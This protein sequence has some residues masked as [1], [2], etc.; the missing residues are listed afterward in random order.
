MLRIAPAN[1]RTSEHMMA[2]LELLHFLHRRQLHV[3]QPIA[4]KDGAY[5]QTLSAPEGPRYAVLFTFVPGAPYQPTTTDSQRY[6]QALAQ[7]H[8][9][10]HDYPADRAAWHF[11]PAAMI[12]QPLALLQPWFTDHP[13]DFAYLMDI[14][15]TLRQA[16][17]Q[18]PRT[19]PAYGI[20][21][22]DVNNGNIHFMEER[23]WALLDF[24]YV[25]YGW[26]VFDIAT[27]FNNQLVEHGKTERTQRL[28]DAF[29]EGYQSVR[30]LSQLELEVLPSFVILRQF[31]LW[32]IGVKFQANIG[33]ALF[34]DWVFERCLPF[35]KAWMQSP[36]RREAVSKNFEQR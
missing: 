18:L 35:V 3:P 2:E 23:Q 22:G 19:A 5:V 15:A 36:D 14:A 17:S 28:L 29:L 9:I 33:F 25:G 12:D 8:D 27:F 26:R 31:W 21:H 34:Q 24:E 7:F 30:P 32:G 10:T 13:A 16:T 4:C 6:G 1:W 20:C 11:E